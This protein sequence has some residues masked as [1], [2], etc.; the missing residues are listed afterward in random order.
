MA[1]NIL[2]PVKWTGSKRT[3]AKRIIAN[4]PDK[5]DLYIEPFLGSGAVMMELLTNHQDRLW[6]GTR[7]IA[8]D[9]NPDLVQIWNLCKWNPKKISD[10]YRKEW[11]KRNTLNNKLRPDDNSQEM[12]DHRNEHYYALRDSYNN[13]YL[14]GGEDAA[15]ELMCLLAFDFN[16]LV[17]YGKK[18]FNA[19]C[20]PVVP[21]IHPDTKEEIINN[22]S[23]LM[24]KYNIDVRC[25]SYDDLDATDTKGAVIYC[26]PPY[27]MFLNEKGQDGVYNSGDFDLD[28]FGYWCK[29]VE[30][31]K[32]LVSFDSGDV[33]REYFPEVM[34]DKITNDT[35][36]SK[37]RRQMTKT[38][39]PKK[40]MR[41][42][43]SLYIRK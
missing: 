12:Q 6:H 11:T 23:K 30:C 24:K 25:Q 32:L 37:F 18:G 19:S 27:K 41:T 14:T 35:G 17:R 7:V 38:R 43:E 40:S 3:Q 26:D 20:M 4:F 9:V 1:T 5:I 28:N 33:G 34:F 10:F 31:E 16:G 36:T 13:H 2:T 21:G 8:S 42:S 15:M 22:I 29:N 39:E